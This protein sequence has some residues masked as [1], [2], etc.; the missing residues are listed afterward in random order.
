MTAFPQKRFYF[1]FTLDTEPDDLW[2]RGN[3]GGFSHFEKLHEF[4]RELSVRGAE[5]V[6]L[7]T[8]EVAEDA[9]A[10]RVMEK[11]LSEGNAELGAHFH[12]WTRQWPFEVPDLGVPPLQ[13]MAHRLGQPV[14]ERML[15][16]TCGSL[17]KALGIRPTSYRGGRW[18]FDADSIQS[19]L[20]C[21]ISVDTTVTPGR[22]WEDASD[23]LVSGPDY[24]SFPR[25]PFFLNR[26]SLEPRFE[27]GELLELPVG[28]TYVAPENS[29][30]G[31]PACL[32]RSPGN[33]AAGKA[34]GL[35]LAAAHQHE[36]GRS[37]PL[38]S[39]G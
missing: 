10:R 26:G 21:G 22:T 20:N 11:I 39:P 25:G 30:E 29:A 23:S 36:S 5:P 3:S 19:L 8:S 17:Q 24:R 16:Y 33:A 15:E 7:T 32:L 28:A 18:S 2:Q 4:H 13:A 9:M 12:T 38:A 27:G 37:C 14:E 34:H 1:C 6:Y 31:E 35:A